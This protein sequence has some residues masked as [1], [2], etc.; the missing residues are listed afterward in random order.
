M[1]QKLFTQT[2]AA[3]LL[4]VGQTASAAMAFGN[5]TPQNT[6]AISCG[7]QIPYQGQKL[8]VTVDRG[9]VNALKVV[10]VTG[11][12]RGVVTVGYL[13]K[14]TESQDLKF[15][16][17]KSADF[18]MVVDADTARANLKAKVNGE[19]KEFNNLKC[20]FNQ[21]LPHPGVTMGN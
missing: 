21:F 5:Q 14:K 15:E 2:L 19:V 7:P 20:V 6:P 8:V 17:F 13:V 4:L 10:L 16:Y 11:D 1:N 12:L 3:V 9:D 18:S